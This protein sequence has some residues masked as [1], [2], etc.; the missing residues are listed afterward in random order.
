VLFSAAIPGQ[1]GRH[2]VN[3]QF[4]S[5]WITRFAMHGFR[6]FDALRPVLWHRAEVAVWYRQN[7]LVFS[8][9]KAFPGERPAPEQYDLVHPETWLAP[10][11]IRRRIQRSLRGIGRDAA[12]PLRSR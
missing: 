3:E 1:G 4:P 9:H 12:K 8:R 6:C 5:Y 10:G 11:L 2:H 7:L